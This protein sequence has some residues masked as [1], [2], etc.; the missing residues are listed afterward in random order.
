LILVCGEA[1]IDAIEDADGAQ[2]MMPGGGPFNTARALARLGVP[3][4]FVGHLSTDTSGRR[5]AD[6]LTADGASL[7]FASY[8]PEPTT[9]AVARVDSAGLA[10]FEFSVDGTSAPNLTPAMIPDQLPPDV[11]AIHV[12]TLGLV[13]EPMASTLTL[14]IERHGGGRLIMLDP[15]IRPAVVVDEVRYRDRLDRVIGIST[16]VKASEA[17]LRWLSPELGYQPAADLIL[18]GGTRL[19]I[20]TLGPAGAYAITADCRVMVEAPQ[21]EVVDTIGAGDSFSAALLAWLYDHDRLKAALKLSP[22]ELRSALE[23]A[24][25][26]ASLACARAGAEPPTRA[27][28][29]RARASADAG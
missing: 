18:N 6:L 26:A 28:M 9:V 1:L 19:V 3:A 25:L 29:A 13:L 10:E 23:F 7:A 8:G 12:G 27:E 11:T 14:L 5:L 21:V 20:V 17:D 16:I 2:R 24:C 22:D 15:N 4:A